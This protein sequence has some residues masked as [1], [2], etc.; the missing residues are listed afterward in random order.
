MS[1]AVYPISAY[2]S[3]DGDLLIVAALVN[4]RIKVT[5]C[6]LCLPPMDEIFRGMSTAGLFDYWWPRVRDFFERAG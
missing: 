5:A 4:G 3:N 1:A 2:K 6:P